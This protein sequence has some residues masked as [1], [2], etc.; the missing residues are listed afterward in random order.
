MKT[1]TNTVIVTACESFIDGIA[2]NQ[3]AEAVNVS[4]Y[5]TFISTLNPEQ[6]KETF[7]AL[8]EATRKHDGINTIDIIRVLIRVVTTEG[9][10]ED[11]KTV[12]VPMT[13]TSGN[14]VRG[15]ANL[16]FLDIHGNATPEAI[17]K[18]KSCKAALSREL[19]KAMKSNR[20]PKGKAINKTKDSD[21]V[22]SMYKKCMEMSSNQREALIAMLVGH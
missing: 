6:W 12:R 3:K 13:D 19:P 22:S 15:A 14:F 2:S 5:R 9:K 11:G 7:T 21:V 1:K 18:L 16:I 10:D 17:K 8:S 4:S 20:S